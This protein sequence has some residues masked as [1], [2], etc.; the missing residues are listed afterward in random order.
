[1]RD[2]QNKGNVCWAIVERGF[3]SKNLNWIDCFIFSFMNGFKIGC[4]S[5]TLSTY[6]GEKL[7]EATNSLFG[8]YV[9]RAHVTQLFHR[10]TKVRYYALVGIKK[11]KSFLITYKYFIR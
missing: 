8:A 9:D 1:L 4:Y 2:I 5:F 3:V 6:R 11:F 7:A 10:I